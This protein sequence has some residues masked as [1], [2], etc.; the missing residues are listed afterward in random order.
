MNDIHYRDFAE[1]LNVEAPDVVFMHWMVDNHRDHRAISTLSYDA[2]LKSGR[3]FALYYHEVSDG[4]DT[5]QFSPPRYVDIARMEARKKAACYAH[6]SQTPDRR[7][8]AESAPR[9]VC[10]RVHRNR[11]INPPVVSVRRSSCSLH[12]DLLTATCVKHTE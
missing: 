9:G 5:M 2:W 4:E 7:R 3:K 12:S 1:R 8:V 11:S 6:A 10:C